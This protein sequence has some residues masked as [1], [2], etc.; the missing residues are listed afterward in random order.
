MLKELKDKAIPLL[1]CVDG[2][3]ILIKKMPISEEPLENLIQRIIPNAKAEDFFV[4]QVIGAEDNSF[5][6]LIRRSSLK[7]LID[8]IIKRGFFI[9]HLNIGPA[10][11]SCISGTLTTGDTFKELSWRNYSLTFSPEGLHEL[12][13]KTQSE[14]ST[15][16]FES[17]HFLKFSAAVAYF[18]GWRELN[19][20][21]MCEEIGNSSLS[22][23][24]KKK[25]VLY[26]YSLVFFFLIALLSN[27]FIFQHYWSRQQQLESELGWQESAVKN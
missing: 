11:S 3:G 24:Q 2:K 4:E 23:T 22:F 21:L 25:F 8:E 1:L 27:F 7:N 12:S 14:E 16:P 15:L 18:S 20:T 10:V 19:S 5:V 13:K 17:K 9:C 6:S 26:S